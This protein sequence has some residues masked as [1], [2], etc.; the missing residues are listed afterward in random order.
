MLFPGNETQKPLQLVHRLRRAGTCEIALAQIQQQTAVRGQADAPDLAVADVKDSPN[1]GIILLPALEDLAR[2][3]D[4]RRILA[5]LKRQGVDAE[6][7]APQAGD[8]RKHADFR[9]QRAK[10]V[11]ALADERGKRGLAARSK[12]TPVKLQ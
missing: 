9:R 10:A 3:A 1:E 2:E 4:L 8:L 7:P 12:E 5:D 6:K 11:L